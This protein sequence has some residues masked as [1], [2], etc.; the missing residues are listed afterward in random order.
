MNRLQKQHI[1]FLCANIIIINDNEEEKA[2]F[3]FKMQIIVSYFQLLIPILNRPHNDTPHLE[4]II[5]INS[6]WLEILVGR[7]QL[8]I[9]VFLV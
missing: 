4:V 7:S 9:P 6:D 3:R 8:D 5:R 2:C 1:V